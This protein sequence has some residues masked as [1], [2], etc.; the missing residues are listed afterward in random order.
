MSE[1]FNL[2][3]VQ[4]NL[5]YLHHRDRSIHIER[6]CSADD[7]PSVS[8]NR[9]K[10]NWFIFT[11][12]IIS[13]EHALSM[14]ILRSLWP[15]LILLQMLSFSW[16]PQS[17][18]WRH[19]GCSSGPS[20]WS[21]TCVAS[22]T[23]IRAL[24]SSSIQT[25]TTKSSPSSARSRRPRSSRHDSG[26]KTRPGVSVIKLFFEMGQP[27]HLF[28]FFGLFKQTIQFLQQFNVKKC[29]VH[30]VYSAGIQTH[31]LSNMSRLP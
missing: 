15:P 22:S 25:W 12:G 13:A 14:C 11:E 5:P 2:P 6:A 10:S 1:A 4:K 19:H 20:S 23:P 26:E 7:K 17:L 3:L 8:I 18:R 16:M 31:G 24:T 29:H 27:R 9:F 30:P 28:C 21:F